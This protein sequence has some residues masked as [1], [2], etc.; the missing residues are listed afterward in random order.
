MFGLGAAISAANAAQRAS[1]NLERAL[2]HNRRRRRHPRA[3]EP[4]RVIG[5][6]L[7]ATPRRRKRPRRSWTALWV[8]L[9]ASVLFGLSLMYAGIL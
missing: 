3:D 1:R 2:R 8:L 7:H 6:E 9:G 5:P 4:R